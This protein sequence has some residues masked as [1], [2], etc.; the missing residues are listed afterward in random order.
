MSSFPLQYNL[1]N[2]FC[3]IFKAFLKLSLGINIKT[4]KNSKKK[5][6]A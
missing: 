1:Q 2:H 6:L 4:S 5:M 3:L